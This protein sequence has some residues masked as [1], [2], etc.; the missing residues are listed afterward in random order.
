MRGNFGSWYSCRC[1]FDRHHPPKHHWR[2]STSP[3]RWQRPPPAG[4]SASCHVQEW[5][6]EHDKEIHADPSVTD[7]P[8]NVLEQVRFTET[9]SHNLQD[10]KDPTW[11]QPPQC[12]LYILLF[13]STSVFYSNFHSILFLYF[14]CC[15]ILFTILFDV[16]DRCT[17]HWQSLDVISIC[18]ENV[19]TI[20][21]NLAFSIILIFWCFIHHSSVT[22]D[23]RVEYM[24]ASV[25]PPEA[26]VQFS[27]R[28]K[29]TSALLIFT[30]HLSHTRWAIYGHKMSHLTCGSLKVHVLPLQPCRNE[31]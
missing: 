13:L 29:M 3:P 10:S 30:Q 7:H 20:F 21:Y 5:P 25:E 27:C 31:V 11:C 2:P 26:C 6:K 1:H 19:H 24:L 22:L 12:N 15:S 16:G 14:S 23:Q 17:M 9:P 28:R 4:H 8:E 18:R